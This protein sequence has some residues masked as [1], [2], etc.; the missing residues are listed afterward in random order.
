VGTAS[1]VGYVCFNL[2]IGGWYSGIIAEVVTAQASSTAR[3]GLYSL[4]HGR[5]D[6][7]LEETGSIDTSTTGK[8][9]GT[10]GANIH[11]NCGWWA[12]ALISTDTLV[13]WRAHP[14]D[15]A[16]G[17][18]FGQDNATTLAHPNKMFYHSGTGIVLPAT[19]TATGT[20]GREAVTLGL[21]HV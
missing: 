18:P 1:E 6:K 8:K 4:V 7:K 14:T 9:T 11:L 5:P 17:G 13:D 3:F 21:I 16:R 12:L 15:S 2:T 10:F 20:M 19:A